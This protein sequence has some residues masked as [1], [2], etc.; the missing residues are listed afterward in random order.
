MTTLSTLKAHSSKLATGGFLASVLAVMGCQ[1][2]AEP[3]GTISNP[4]KANSSTAVVSDMSQQTLRQQALRIQRALANKDFARI[5]DDIHPTRGVRFSMYAYIRPETDKVFSREQYAQYLQQ[6]KT[7]FTWGEKD[8]TG[9]PLV[10][11]LPTY[12][13][14]WVNGAIFNNASISLNDF[15]NNGNSINNLKTIYPNLDVVEFYYKGSDEY[16]GMDWRVLRLVFDDYQGKRYLVAIINDQ[17]T[18]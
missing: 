5:V 6:S 1:S 15:K 4:A 17:W 13:D 9:D 18:V 3:N 7:R 12:L 2:S 8:G 11:T 14:T 10:E 16:S